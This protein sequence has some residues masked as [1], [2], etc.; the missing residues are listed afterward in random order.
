MVA[1]A[2]A[3]PDADPI[4]QNRYDKSV[5]AEHKQCS[6]GSRVQND[7]NADD[8]PVQFPVFVDTLNIA[9]QEVSLKCPN[10]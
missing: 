6:D 4:E 9:S 7:Q 3:Q 5:P 8:G 1:H 10:P 2:D